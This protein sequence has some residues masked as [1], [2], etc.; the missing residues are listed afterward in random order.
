MTLFTKYSTARIQSS[1]KSKEDKFSCKWKEV[2]PHPAGIFHM[3]LTRGIIRKYRCSKQNKKI[4]KI[5]WMKQTSFLR[6]WNWPQLQEWCQG[7][8]TPPVWHR[9]AFS[10]VPFRPQIRTRWRSNRHCTAVPKFLSLRP[11]FSLI[12]CS[13]RLPC[14]HN[15][16]AGFWHL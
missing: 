15:P 2:L 9:T 7:G 5:S 14:V 10:S 16:M 13:F 8:Y 12:I 11:D 4:L 3:E 6:S 1:L